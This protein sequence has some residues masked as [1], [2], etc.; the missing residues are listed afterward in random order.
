[1][2]ARRPA[3]PQSLGDG[4]VQQNSQRN[5]IQ[6]HPAIAWSVNSLNRDRMLWDAVAGE[7]IIRSPNLANGINRASCRGE[8]S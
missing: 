2:E 3:P 7:A 1:M 8:R 5:R 6:S 4:E